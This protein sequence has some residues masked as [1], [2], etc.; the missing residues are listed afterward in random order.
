M[1]SSL[2]LATI[3]MAAALDVHVSTHA[4]PLLTN[5]NAETPN[6]QTPFNSHGQTLIS[7]TS[8]V[9]HSFLHSTITVTRKSPPRPHRHPRAPSPTA[10][11]SSWTSKNAWPPSVQRELLPSQNSLTGQTKSR[12]DKPTAG[13]STQKPT[14]GP[15]S[16][17]GGTTRRWRTTTPSSCLTPGSTSTSTTTPT[18]TSSSAWGEDE[19]SP[20]PL[21][22][23]TFRPTTTTD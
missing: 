5:S 22:S 21:P 16:S 11:S 14:A 18:A 1:N 23:A 20:M 12:S 10:P 15:R 13:S 17:L 8:P 7:K 3:G 2:I 4:T 6:A 19:S 9:Y